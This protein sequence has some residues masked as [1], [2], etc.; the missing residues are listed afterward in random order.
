ME[1]HLFWLHKLSICDA[2]ALSIAF[3]HK[4]MFFTAIK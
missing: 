1:M 3:L 2:T 4:K